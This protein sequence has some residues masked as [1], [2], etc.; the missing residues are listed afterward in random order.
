VFDCDCAR[1]FCNFPLGPDRNA[2]RISR[3]DS[4]Q[5]QAVLVGEA[6]SDL[7]GLLFVLRRARSSA[8]ADRGERYAHHLDR[9][10]RDPDGH[11]VLHDLILPP[12]RRGPKYFA[13]RTARPTLFR[14]EDGPLCRSRRDTTG[15][16]RGEVGARLRSNAAVRI[17]PAGM[18]W[19][20]VAS[21]RTKRPKCG[22]KLSRRRSYRALRR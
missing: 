2:G 13:D 19:I 10:C 22:S 15:A 9:D 5:M 4:P 16:N 20:S 1:Y 8:D 21:A 12:V 3:I 18:P 11:R 6:R 17:C 14:S 7:S